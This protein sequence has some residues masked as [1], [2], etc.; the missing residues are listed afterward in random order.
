MS[1]SYFQEHQN[2]YI[3]SLGVTIPDQTVALGQFRLGPTVRGDF[4]TAGGLSYQPVF[5]LDAIY[6]FGT[7]RGVVTTNSDTPHTDGWRGRLKAG[8]N[9]M[10]KGGSTLNL[11]AI[12]DGLGQSDFES[13]GISFELNIPLAKTRVQ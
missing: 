11:N 1:L 5:A 6:N 8:V 12:Y 7:T 10:T 4:Q 13:W 3:D 9:L 2:S